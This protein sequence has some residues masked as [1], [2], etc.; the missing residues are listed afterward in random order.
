VGEVAVISGLEARPDG[1]GEQVREIALG[2]LGTDVRA[3]T[4]F[5]EHVGRCRGSA[6]AG[7]A[8]HAADLDD[9]EADVGVPTLV[10]KT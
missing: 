7:V 9:V 1:R 8:E 4:C 5:L 2:E 10:A 6:R 3:V